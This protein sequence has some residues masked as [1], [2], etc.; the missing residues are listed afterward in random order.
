[1]QQHPA[2]TA[3]LSELAAAAEAG[4][5]AASDYLATALADLGIADDTAAEESA[6]PVDAQ[7]LARPSPE[8]SAAA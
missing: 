7:A 6:N 8:L 3:L 1:M 4:R 2:G 5:S